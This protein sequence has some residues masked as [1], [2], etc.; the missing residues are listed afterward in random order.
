MNE[1]NMVNS[2]GGSQDPKEG[3]FDEIS[4]SG[5]KELEEPTSSR[6]TGHLVRGGVAIL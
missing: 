3:T 1:R 2:L 6:K 4:Y 5:E